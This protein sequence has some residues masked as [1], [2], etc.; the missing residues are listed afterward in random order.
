MFYIFEIFTRKIPKIY[1]LGIFQEFNTLWLIIA[2]MVHYR[3]FNLVVISYKKFWH[4]PF[5]FSLYIS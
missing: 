1:I 4:D 5:F 3:V 2:T